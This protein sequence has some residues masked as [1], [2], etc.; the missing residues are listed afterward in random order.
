M[1]I[2]SPD[3]RG[4][5]SGAEE[6]ISGFPPLIGEDEDVFAGAGGLCFIKK[7]RRAPNVNEEIAGSSPKKRSSSEWYE[8]ESAPEA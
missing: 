1:R 3:A 8:I 2:M 4:S 6:E 5:F 7:S